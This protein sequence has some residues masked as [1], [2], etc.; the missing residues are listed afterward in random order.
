MT[1]SLK[2]VSLLWRILLSTSLTVTAL[3]ALTGW[4]VQ[5][6]A[7]RVS[8]HSLEEE[9]KT[10]VEAYQAYWSAR[11]HTVGTVSKIISSMSDVRAA[12]QTGDKATIR[13]TAEQLWS[14]V[15]EQDATFLVLDPAGN[16]ITS[17]G[18][19]YSNVEISWRELNSAMRSFPEQVAGFLARG[20][21][22]YYVVLTPVYVQSSAGKALLNILLMAVHVDHRLADTL[23]TSTNGSDFLFYAG[24]VVV[25]STLGS[26]PA[27]IH[28][29]SATAA[30]VNRAVVGGADY[31]VVGTAI[32]DID[33]H[34]IGR[35]Y[36]MRPFAGPRRA[37]SELQ[38][39]VGFIWVIA[40]VIGFCTT[41]LLARRIVEPVRRLDRAAEEV[42]KENYD[43]R[44]P[45]ETDDELGRLA[46]TFN[47]MCDS[48][49]K[50]RDELIRQERIATIGRFATSIV[51]DLRSPLAAIYGGAE[52]LVDAT[53]SPEQTHRLAANMYRASRRIQ[54]LLQDL[55]DVGRGRQR[56]LE[57]CFVSELVNSAR[58]SVAQNA[59]LENI[60]VVLEIPEDLDVVVERGRMER[61]FMNLLNNARD[62]MPAGGAVRITA[63]KEQSSV[64]VAIEDTGPGLSENAWAT[65]FQPFS[66]FG[67][68]NGLGLG[69]ALARHAVLEHGGELWAQKKTGPGAIFYIRLPLASSSSPDMPVDTT[70]SSGVG[71]V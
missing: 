70:V 71:H 47:T 13:D 59:D 64:L 23:K 50:A 52:M 9:V 30:G 3:F 12:F 65:L 54:E 15:S 31:L 35:L 14:Q 29:P 46:R 1:I 32:R 36:V 2:S 67:K 58:E 53:L 42:I 51:H 6:Y 33:N 69:L 27:R 4:M 17:L 18:G 28:T 7:V 16:V 68:R 37:L 22:L 60:T 49:R 56:P 45:I 62:V 11:A 10:S 21:T 48:I 25:A 44:V 57:H 63:T 38:R 8:E 19:D 20:Q 26:L 66:S 41:Y 5:T 55:T 40:I 24:D 43:Y 39:N 61:V 34:P